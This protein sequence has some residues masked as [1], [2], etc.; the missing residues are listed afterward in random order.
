M[1]ICDALG[2]RIEKL[3]VDKNCLTIE[4]LYDRI[5]DV[6][7]EAGRPELVRQGT[8]KMIVFPEIDKKNQVQIMHERHGYFVQRSVQPAGMSCVKSIISDD[9]S[10]E[11]IGLTC[12]F[13]VSKRYCMEL[14]SKTAETINTIGI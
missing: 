3:K 1:L 8:V 9:V 2:I 14:V 10:D 5:K 6:Y 7:F 4:D 12:I 13:S 11:H